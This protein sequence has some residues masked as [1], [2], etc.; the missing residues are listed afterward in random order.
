VCLNSE[1]Y[2]WLVSLFFPHRKRNLRGC[3]GG[4]P[5]LLT[6]DYIAAPNSHSLLHSQLSYRHSLIIRMNPSENGF[7]PGFR[8]TDR[9]FETKNPIRLRH[10]QTPAQLTDHSKHM[11]L[12]TRLNVSSGNTRHPNA[13]KWNSWGGFFSTQIDFHPCSAV[14]TNIEGCKLHVRPQT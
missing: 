6:L 11:F 13:A 1:T 7:E 8:P 14:A 4:T 3:G 2:K 5:H 12:I 10:P 9:F